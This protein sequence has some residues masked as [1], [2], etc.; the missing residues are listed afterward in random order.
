MKAR[1]NNLG[2][3][4]I[5]LFTLIISMLIATVA[6]ADHR[7][8]LMPNCSGVIISTM[9]LTTLGAVEPPARVGGRVSIII[10]TLTWVGLGT[11]KI[12]IPMM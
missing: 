8:H 5:I 10:T 11:G 7:Q 12:R 2:K 6:Y 1:L 3:K 4:G 9:C